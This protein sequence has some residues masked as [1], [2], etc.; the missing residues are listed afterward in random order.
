[1][2]DYTDNCYMVFRISGLDKDTKLFD[3]IV[4][5]LYYYKTMGQMEP[6]KWVFGAVTVFSLD[7]GD[8]TKE[9]GGIH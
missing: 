9:L 7:V 8:I 5:A 6:D 2:Q 1:M 3:D 4:D